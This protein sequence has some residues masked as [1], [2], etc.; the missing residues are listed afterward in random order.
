[1]QSNITANSV[2]R[3]RLAKRNRENPV[4]TPRLAA[5]I[6]AKRL[7]DGALWYGIMGGDYD[8]LIAIASNLYFSRT[9]T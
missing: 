7:T 3:F 2:S 9:I 8:G 5:T 4:R 6:G 1:M